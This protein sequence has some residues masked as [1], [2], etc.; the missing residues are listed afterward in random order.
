MPD[1]YPLFI[2]GLPRSGTKLL[3][4]LLNNHPDISLAGEGRFIPSTVKRFGID[5]DVSQRGLWQAVY[6]KISRQ[7]F[8]G[9]PAKGN[10][11]LSEAAFL[12]ALDA[13]KEQAPLTWAVI[14]EAI[15]R[16]Y[17]PRP[18]ALI[19]GD[20]SH[21]YINNVK[22]IRTVFKDVRFIFI[23]RDPRDQALSAQATW[24]RHPLRSAT[25]WAN[26]AR[27]VKRLDL[28]SAADTLVIRYEDLTS[29]TE[30]QLKRVCTFLQLPYAAEMSQLKRPAESRK[31]LKTV[32]RQHARYR[33]LL[34]L[35]TIKAISEI[36]LPYLAEYGYSDEGVTRERRLSRAQLTL[37]SYT[38]G[39]ASLRHHIREKGLRK[40]SVY[41][42]SKHFES[43]ED[44]PRTSS[45]PAS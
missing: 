40:G 7:V 26:A 31:Q 27:T 29:D 25:H 2:I 39:L 28:S 21:G 3:R 14:F 20:K 4:A 15:M 43:A 44:A 8:F 11:R 19:Y 17:G 22:L 24:G 35:S 32:V 12:D 9:T 36:T 16:P 1:P 38:D 5:A 41:Y 30:S 18:Q 13:R 37:L 33:E 34:P 10:V 23:V 6:K 45:Q 42:L